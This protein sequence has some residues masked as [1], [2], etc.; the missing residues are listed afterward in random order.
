MTEADKK[1]AKEFF[2]RLLEN[3]DELYDEDLMVFMLSDAR[4][5]IPVSGNEEM[6][7]PLAEEVREAFKKKYNIA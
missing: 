6:L 4:L 2:E 7:Y 5:G 1:F 3:S